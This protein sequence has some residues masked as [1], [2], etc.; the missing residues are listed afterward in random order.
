MKKI[1]ILFAILVCSAVAKATD[2]AF[3]ITGKLEA[4]KSG[5]V[6]LLIY[7]DEEK[8]LTAKIING[9]FTLQGFI[10][11]PSIAYLDI[12][13]KKQD[14]LRFYVEPG[15]IQ[16]AGKGYPLNDLVISN[17]PINDDD[18][19]LKQLMLPI[20]NW[21]E[22]NAKLYEK[23]LKANNKKVLDSLDEVDFEVLHQKRKVVA[24][25]VK[26]HPNSVRSAM[27]IIENYA[28]YAEADEVEPLY[29]L[30][31]N[32][33]KKTPLGEELKKLIALYKTVSIGM[34]APD[35]TQTTPQGSPLSLSSLKGKYVLVDFWASWCKPCRRENPNVVKLYHQFKNKDFDVF[36]VSYDLKKEKWLNAIKED[37]LTWNHVSD[38]QGWKNATSTVYGIKAI[39]SNVLIDK[40]GKIIAKNIFGKKLSEKINEVIK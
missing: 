1:N 20:N 24:S 6:T 9:T 25:F 16:I 14:Y 35:I 17:S 19:I 22:A 23:A 29:N 37:G 15:S 28:Y 4:I 21:E 26:D 32:N 18:K 3:T 33:I 27:A 5:T 12:Q 34:M 30:L 2:S 8:K 40:E 36:S 7:G 38:L 10:Q 11:K 39:P 31:D 13:D